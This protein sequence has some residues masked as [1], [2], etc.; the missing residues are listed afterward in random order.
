MDE[1][2]QQ[3]IDMIERGSDRRVTRTASDHEVAAALATE[4]GELLLECARNSPT[5]RLPNERPR[6]T[7]APTTS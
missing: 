2:A 7:S 5:P 4:A 3:V 1:L 6:G